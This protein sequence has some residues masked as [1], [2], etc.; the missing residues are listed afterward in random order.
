MRKGFFVTGT[1]VGVGKTVVAAGIAG[2]LASMEFNVGI[3]KPVATDGFEDENGK[4]LSR[5]A[6]YLRR[7]S[8]VKDDLSIVNPYLYETRVAPSVAAYVE[9]REE[10]DLKLVENR[11]FE[12]TLMHEII[13]IDGEGGLMAPMNRE[14]TT[15]DLVLQLGAELIVVARPGHGTISHTLLTV[16]HARAMG[17]HV[18]GVVINAWGRDG[19]GLIEKTNPEEI[20]RMCPVPLLG[21]LPWMDGCNVETGSHQ[22][23]VETVLT[24]LDLEPLIRDDS[25]DWTFDLL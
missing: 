5:D 17:V 24:K 13:V 21:I 1:D 4:L 7:V 16:N 2:A 14:E 8:G 15:L 19:V 9:K 10:V 18:A 20:R 25:P 12:L 23:L 6:E 22:G 11:Y 3:M